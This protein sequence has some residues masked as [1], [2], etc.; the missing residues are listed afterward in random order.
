MHESKKLDLMLF[1][2]KAK[3]DIPGY[4][5]A[6]KRRAFISPFDYYRLVL[7]KEIFLKYLPGGRMLDIGA[8]IGA[9]SGVYKS[10]CSEVILSDIDE[11]IINSANRENELDN[12]ENLRYVCADA[13]NLAFKDRRFNAI[14]NLETIEHLPAC[15][16]EQVIEEMLRVTREGG[17]IFLSTPNSFSL[18]GLE[19]KLMELIKR[20]FK[21]TAWD[22]D[23][24]CVYSSFGFINFLKRFD[25]K[26]QIEEVYGSYFLPGSITVRMPFFIHRVLGYVSYLMAKASRYLLPLRYTGFTIIVILKKRV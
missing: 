11:F 23:H 5:S 21:W 7:M 10:R 17:T 22:P 4:I 6:R 2:A 25:N 19:G 8:N 18:A 16:Q 15:D 24:K 14:V 1:K 9:M 13:K 26:L 12:G 20:G 3:K